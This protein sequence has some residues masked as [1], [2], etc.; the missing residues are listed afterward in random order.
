MNRER[1]TDKLKTEL[2]RLPPPERLYPLVRTKKLLLGGLTGKLV[3]DGK[4]EAAVLAGIFALGASLVSARLRQ[5]IR[6]S[7]LDF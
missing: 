5:E 6:R 1:V 3:A 4:P 7:R 2:L